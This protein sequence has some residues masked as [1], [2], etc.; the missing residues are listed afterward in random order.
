MSKFGFEGV[1][2][3]FLKLLKAPWIEQIVIPEKFAEVLDNGSL[4]NISELFLNNSI[5]SFFE[6]GRIFHPCGGGSLV[7]SWLG[8][9]AHPCGARNYCFLCFEVFLHITILQLLCSNCMHLR[10]HST[11][12]MT[13]NMNNFTMYYFHWVARVLQEKVVFLNWFRRNLDI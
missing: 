13:T 2:Q 1:P 8:F 6:L 5:F 11:S 12:Q 10:G 3:R 4:E 9:S 7:V